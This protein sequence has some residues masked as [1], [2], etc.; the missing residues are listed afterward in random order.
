MYLGSGQQSLMLRCSA[1]SYFCTCVL[2]YAL[3][4]CFP[5]AN[6]A[7]VGEVTFVTA[8]HP[9]DCKSGS[10]RANLFGPCVDHAER[11]HPVAWFAAIELDVEWRC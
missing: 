6:V 11:S 1:L 3:P 5:A 7:E 9:S 8:D 10:L 4:I 2:L